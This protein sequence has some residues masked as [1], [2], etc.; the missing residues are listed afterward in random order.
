MLNLFL[1][2]LIVSKH[3]QMRSNFIFLYRFF[4]FQNS[5]SFYD[6]TVGEPADFQGAQN[7]PGFVQV[8]QY[9]PAN[10]TEEGS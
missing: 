8:H 10:R 5:R 2:T 4:L 3:E 6:S 9:Q 7:R 1:F